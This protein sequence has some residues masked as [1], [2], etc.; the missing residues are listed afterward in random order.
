MW[1]GKARE[2]LLPRVCG[3]SNSTLC[4]LQRGDTVVERA[5]YGMAC[6]CVGMDWA[7]R[8]HQGSP[9]GAVQVTHCPVDSGQLCGHRGPAAR[10]YW[11]SLLSAH[12]SGLSNQWLL[13]VVTTL[14][15]HIVRANASQFRQPHRDTAK[16]ECRRRIPA[17]A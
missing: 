9:C 1:T 17:T 4:M 12:L 2:G 5:L 7:A 13:L 3:Y 6:G 10:C 14:T 8:L 11:R 16:A 15:Y